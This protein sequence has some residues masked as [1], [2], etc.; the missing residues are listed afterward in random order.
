MSTEQHLLLVRHGETQ[1]NRDQIAHGQ[2]ESPLNERGRKQAEIT[3]KMLRGWERTYDKIYCSPLSRAY[4]TAQ[5]IADALELPISVHSGLME[6]NLGDLEGVTYKQLHEFGYAK[7]SIRDDDF[8]GHNGESPNAVADR[9]EES[10]LEIRARHPKENLIVVS[11]GGAIAHLIARLTDSKPAFGPQFIM[12]NAAVT[13]IILS[14]NAAPEIIVLNHHD[15][16]PEEFKIDP[17]SGD[18]STQGK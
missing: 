2:T 7:H 17:K 14:E 6:S 12:H 13:E 15:H 16:L 9:I 3:A 18:P 4:D 11:H 5:A 1:G 8:T 10:I